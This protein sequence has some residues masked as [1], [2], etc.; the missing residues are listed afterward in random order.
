[1]KTRTLVVSV[2]AGTAVLF[3]GAV[4]LCAGAGYYGYQS[5]QAF[6]SSISPQ[7]DELFAAMA[8]DRWLDTYDTHTCAEFRAAVTR[9]Q[10]ALIGQTVSSNL[11]E[12][13]SKNLQQVNVRAMN[14]SRY[15]D[16]RHSAQFATGPGVIVTRW[17]WEDDRWRLLHLNVNSPALAPQVMSKCPHCGKPA[18][19]SAKFCPQCGK[20]L[21]VSE[22]PPKAESATP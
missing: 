5:Y 10:Y 14:S 16:V 13:K 20:E 12:L 2:L 19:A 21:Q 15:A 8:G 17:K 18:P 9:E 1:M 7:V 4:A 22:Q 6:N 11:G 3:L